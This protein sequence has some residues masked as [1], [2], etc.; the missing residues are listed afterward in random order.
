LSLAAEAVSITWRV[1]RC[2][3]ISIDAYRICGAIRAIEICAD[4]NQLTA[5][6]GQ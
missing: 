3:K 5:N 2:R 4:F 6:E 1:G